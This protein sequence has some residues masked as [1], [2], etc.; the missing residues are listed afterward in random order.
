MH[1]EGGLGLVGTW[2]FADMKVRVCVFSFAQSP[3][4]SETP[5]SATKWFH[6][7]PYKLLLSSHRILLTT[8]PPRAHLEEQMNK[9]TRGEKNSRLK[10]QWNSAMVSQAHHASANVCPNLLFLA[11]YCLKEIILFSERNAAAI[12]SLEMKEGKS[13]ICRVITESE[14]NPS[15]T[16]H[17]SSTSVS[18]TVW[19]SDRLR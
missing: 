14:L 15:V 6:P 19:L 7:A 18:T 11:L 8:S 2:V 5:C 3:R 17:F 16:A 1:K 9:W 4:V 10:P 12:N 13:E